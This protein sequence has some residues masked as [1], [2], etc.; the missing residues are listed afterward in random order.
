MKYTFCDY[1][2][3]VC[4]LL[5]ILSSWKLSLQKVGQFKEKNYKNIGNPYKELSTD[6]S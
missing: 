6:G 1:F 2:L 4:G 5:D 3:P